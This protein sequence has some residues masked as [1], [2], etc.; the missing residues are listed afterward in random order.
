MISLSLPRSRNTCGWS[1]GGLAPTHMNSC[2]PIS[3]T[4]T[5]ASLW[6]CGTTWSD[7]IFT[8]DGKLRRT[9]LHAAGSNAAHHTHGRA[10]FLEAPFAHL[11]MQMRH[12]LV[13]P[14]KPF[15]RRGCCVKKTA[16][17]L[18]WRR[19]Y[20]IYR[21]ETGAARFGSG[22][23]GSERGGGRRAV[24]ACQRCLCRAG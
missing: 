20:R 12:N 2:E 6:K 5:P 16:Y 14:E 15:F 10:G 21:D 3:M 17:H 23:D 19:K 4:D 9:Q 8:L 13:V 18:G 24:A 7:I 11:L 1:N 22:W